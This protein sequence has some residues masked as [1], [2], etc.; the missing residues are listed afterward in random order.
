M[1]PQQHS[2]SPLVSVLQN[3]HF[4][5]ILY[6]GLL[7]E[8]TRWYE[9]LVLNWLI[10]QDTNSPL[11]LA[12]VWVFQ[13][14]PRPIVAPFAGLMA[15]RFSRH[16]ILIAAQGLSTLIAASILSLLVI[17]VIRPWQVF[18]A[19]FL[20]GITQSLEQPSRRAAIFDIVGQ[21]R[22]VNAISVENMSNNAGRMAG[23]LAGGVLLTFLGFGG[24]YGFVVAVHLLALGLLI[25]LKIPRYRGIQAVESVWRGLREGIGYA[26]HNPTLLGVLYISMVMNALAFP[27]QQFIPAIG[28][29]HLGV[30][31]AL[32]GLLASAWGFGHLISA[33]VVAS[34]RE[35]RYHGRIF[36][37][38]ALAGL[39]V[40]SLFVWS[41]WYALSFAL[42]TLVGTCNAGFG[43]M[44]SPITM[45][46]APPELRG[47]VL[48]LLSFFISVGIPLGTLEIGWMAAAF[49]TQWAIS[50]NALGALLLILPAVML[51]PLAWRPLGEPLP[52][53]SR[54]SLNP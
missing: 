44:Q 42:L 3:S 32:V 12:L 7:R 4:R 38:G 35:I 48:G 16:R 47:R 25:R 53:R 26:M 6:V 19:V 37:M 43:T 51:T 28:R 34:R 29:D 24:A 54:R 2:R 41:P 30:G 27:A 23:P 36:V 10:L 9:L 22:V 18:I 40:V 50:A 33:G 8:N 49:S 52:Q 5:A 20:Q 46:S 15:D 1:E 14:V 31:P 13:S 45:L 17:D 21:R 39:V 11:Q